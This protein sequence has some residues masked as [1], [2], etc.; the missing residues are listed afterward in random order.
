MKQR[1]LQ[2]AKGFTLLEML[3][4][5]TIIAIVTSIITVNWTHWQ[6]NSQRRF[7]T[8][9]LLA[10][11][12]SHRLLAIHEN[13]SYQCQFE[14]TDLICRRFTFNQNGY[15]GWHDPIRKRLLG[16]GLVFQLTSHL[17]EKNPAI[18][19]LSSG[20]IPP[21]LLKVWDKKTELYQISSNG[22]TLAITGESP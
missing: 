20:E 4:V 22:A 11:L 18:Y 5:I 13:V 8:D 9:R 3:I 19:F 16:K 15:M 17:E 12:N 10:E 2:P 6:S 1:N 14:K 7:M 21:F